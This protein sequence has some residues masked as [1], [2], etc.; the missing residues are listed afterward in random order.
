MVDHYSLVQQLT[1]R[2]LSNADRSR[3]LQDFAYELGWRPSD[4][5]E[6]PDADEFAL[7]HLVVEHGL[8]NTALISFLRQ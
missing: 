6:L 3:H 4:R 5:M 2:A 1:G 8:Q 7:G